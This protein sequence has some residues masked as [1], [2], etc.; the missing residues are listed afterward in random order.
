[1]N[2]YECK[3]QIGDQTTRFVYLSSLKADYYN[4]IELT[5]AGRMRS[6]IENE[7]FDIQKNHGYNLGHKYSRISMT[8]M[9][10]YY[11]CMQIAHM[12]NQLF[13]LS[14]LFMPL[15]KGKITIKYLWNYML[16]EMRH[17]L[18]L[19]DIDGLLTRKIQF[20]YQ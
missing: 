13:E 6:N 11:Q 2:W 18:D 4:I 15:L 14:S 20:R 12:I 17:R 1:M 10:N 5:E 19:K 8:A 7:G 3:E 9:K 16:G